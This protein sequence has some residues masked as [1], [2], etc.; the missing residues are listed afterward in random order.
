MKFDGMRG[1]GLS[2]LFLLG[3]ASVVHAT[4]VTTAMSLNFHFKTD[5]CYNENKLGPAMETGIANWRSAVAGHTVTLGPNDGT[6]FWSELAEYDKAAGG[7]DHIND[8]MDTADLMIIGTHGGIRG[9]NE[10]PDAFTLTT[11][12]RSGN[13]HSTCDISSD[14]MEL[15]NDRA[16]FVDFYGCSIVNFMLWRDTDTF[17]TVTER[18]HQ[19]HGFNG[20]MSEGG[21]IGANMD[22]YIDDAFDGAAMLAWVLNETHFHHWSPTSADVCGVSVVRGLDRH[23]AD[24]RADNERYDGGVNWLDVSGG[25][26]DYLHVCNCEGKDGLTG[27]LDC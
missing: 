20:T 22:D 17:E 18:V 4:P 25:T 2:V 1:T 13:P 16:V 15:G 12:T 14:E 11:T 27:V 9:G 6:I 26:S 7:E 24:V 23:D 10:H 8:N 3:A 5:S 21:P 19:V